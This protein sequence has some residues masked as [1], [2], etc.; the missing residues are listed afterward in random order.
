M[1]GTCKKSPLERK[2][3]NLALPFSLVAWDIVM[4][5]GAAELILDYET[6]DYVRDGKSEL[7]GAESGMNHGSAVP[8]VDC[9]PWASFIG[10][11]LS[12]YLSGLS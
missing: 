6:K 1:C 5:A 7:E 8:A 4:M 9:L 2:V 10:M 11:C 12:H 3:F